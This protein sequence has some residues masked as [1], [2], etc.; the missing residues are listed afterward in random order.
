M[1]GRH[2]PVYIHCIEE[3]LGAVDREQLPSTAEREIRFLH[4]HSSGKR[5]SKPGARNG[6]R[7]H[8]VRGGCVTARV[9]TPD[10]GYLAVPKTHKAVILS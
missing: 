9:E 4:V 3:L 2:L 10:R 5:F 7:A 6:A 8:A 1:H